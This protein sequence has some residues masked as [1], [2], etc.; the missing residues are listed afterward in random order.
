VVN[1]AAKVVLHDVQHDRLGLLDVELCLHSK[2]NDNPSSR[3]AELADECVISVSKCTD[4][5]GP[6]KKKVVYTGV[7]TV[8]GA[9]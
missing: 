2:S 4:T 3:K 9:S 8:H 1:D 7:C 5:D 6:R